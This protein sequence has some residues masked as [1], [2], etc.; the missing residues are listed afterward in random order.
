MERW[1]RQSIL[2]DS[3][4]PSH[5][6]DPPLMLHVGKGHG[7]QQIGGPSDSRWRHMAGGRG[8]VFQHAMFD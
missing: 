2:E 7:A 1:L 5:R 8:D 4:N 3:V 6:D